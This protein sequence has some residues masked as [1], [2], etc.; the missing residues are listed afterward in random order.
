[1]KERERGGG[2]K[3]DYDK[4]QEKEDFLLLKRRFILDVGEKS[5]PF[6]RNLDNHVCSACISLQPLKTL[7]AR[8][9][10]L[11]FSVT[12]FLHRECKIHRFIKISRCDFDK[13]LT[14]D[15][16]I[17]SVIHFQTMLTA[18]SMSAIATNGVVPAGGSYFMISR[19]LQCRRGT[20]DNHRRDC[21][22][23]QFYPIKSNEW[24]RKRISGESWLE[25]EFSPPSSSLGKTEFSTM[26]LVTN[27][28][29]L[30]YL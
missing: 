26:L 14:R 24:L 12:L 3:I 22:Y 9:S 13:S 18:I 7:S 15:H 6:I 8:L 29:Y 1:M 25:S 30:K 20:R 23:N 11:L 5:F 16:F 4:Y 17:I 28:H 2:K 27:F 21:Y 10:A 19:W